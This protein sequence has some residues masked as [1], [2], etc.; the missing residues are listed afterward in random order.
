MKIL[1]IGRNSEKT[2]GLIIEYF[3]CLVQ[4]RSQGVLGPWIEFVFGCVFTRDIYKR[5]SI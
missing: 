5:L 1:K 4:P 2:A 3:V